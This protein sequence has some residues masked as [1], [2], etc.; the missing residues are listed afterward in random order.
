V[1]QDLN[2]LPLASVER[3]LL[4]SSQI[5]GSPAEDVHKWLRT[6][7][8]WELRGRK[9]ERLSGGQ[10]QRVAIARALAKRPKVLILD[11]PTSGLD[12][13]NTGII[14]SAVREFTAGG[15]TICVIATHDHRMEEIADVLVDFHTF[16]SV[17]E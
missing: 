11:E 2:L 17:A 10:C 15:T 13:D 9:V 8:L 5:A 3:N 4:L 1:F 14:K 12:D 6:L 16:L 7:G